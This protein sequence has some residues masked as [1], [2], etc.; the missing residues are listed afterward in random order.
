[1][2]ARIAYQGPFGFI[3]EP[4]AEYREHSDNTVKPISAALY[5]L[6]VRHIL[7]SVTAQDRHDVLKLV[8][9]S[10]VSMLSDGAEKERAFNWGAVLRGGLVLGGRPV[11]RALR[12]DPWQAR[13][14]LLGHRLNGIASS[15]RRT[16]TARRS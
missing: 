11:G 4:L 8:A 15:L 14:L 7:A 13:E 1:M 5:L 10:Y 2:W 6:G 12:D 9:R 16:W 3:G